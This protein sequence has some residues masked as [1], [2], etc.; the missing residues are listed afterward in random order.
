MLKIKLNRLGKKKAPF[1]RVVVV[2]AKSKMGGKVNEVLGNYDPNDPK[3]K[4]EINK[5]RYQF[6]KS[7]GAQPTD[8]VRKL[9]EK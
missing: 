7:K 4:I 2:E 6:W 8:T 5:S 3:N 1:Y 9:V